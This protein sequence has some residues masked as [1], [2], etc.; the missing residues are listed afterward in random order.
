M[1][2]IGKNSSSTGGKVGTAAPKGTPPGKALPAT[3]KR[4]G[5]VAKGRP[6][7]NKRTS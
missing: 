7:K 5:T 4:T 2:G 1:F 3:G 6:P